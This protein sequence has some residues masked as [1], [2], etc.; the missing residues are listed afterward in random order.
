MY[1]LY[2]SIL[3]GFLV[4]S[5]KCIAQQKPQKDTTLFLIG[6]TLN[7]AS[8]GLGF[9]ASTAYQL[10]IGQSQK[11]LYFLF[12]FGV[13][14]YNRSNLI[15]SNHEVDYNIEGFFLQSGFTYFGI[16]IG[17]KEK[18]I[19][20]FVN[21]SYFYGEYNHSVFL[22]VVDNNWGLSQSYEF[23]QFEKIFGLDFDIGFLLHLSKRFQFS[24]AATFGFIPNR[25]NL[26]PSFNN[27]NLNYFT[28]TL[29]LGKNFSVN[30]NVVLSYTLFQLAP[31]K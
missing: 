23:S 2:A 6:Y 11:N 27:F 26:Y 4:I 22:N 10:Q 9:S 8:M 24:A 25:A 15:Q 3:L 30:G 14:R 13:P 28:P 21:V 1:R 18:F 16:P 12:K 19:T 20:H 5:G 7:P 29:G 17:N 31:K